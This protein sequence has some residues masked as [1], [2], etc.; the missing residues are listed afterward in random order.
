MSVSEAAESG[1]RRRSLEALRASLAAA[2]ESSEPRELASLAK[3]FRE[4]LAELDELP[5]GQE[6]S[7]VDDLTARRAGRRSAS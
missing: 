4:V 2:I 6:A 1:D 7:L 3:Q 5:E